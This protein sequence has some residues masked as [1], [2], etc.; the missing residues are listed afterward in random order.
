MKKVK[1][2]W[3]AALVGALLMATLVGVVWARPN[4]RPLA[5]A[6]TKRITIPGGWFHPVADGYDWYNS[7]KLI[8][9]EKHETIQ[10]FTAPVVFPS[11]GQKF[12]V[13]R[14]ALLVHDDNGPAQGNNDACVRLKKTN[15]G[16][17]TEV[18]MSY[19]CSTGSATG[20]RTFTDTVID[21]NPVTTARGAYLWLEIEDD[22]YLFVH[23]VRIWYHKGSP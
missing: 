13:E 5:A 9:S 6:T 15:P 19:V 1:K 7:G 17:G 20:V 14:I 8:Y 23:G 21:N 22:T 12:T 3:I 11:G 16:G 18:L 4:A 2:S 10:Y